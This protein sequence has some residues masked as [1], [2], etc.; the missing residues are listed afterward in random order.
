MQVAREPQPFLRD[1]QLP[2]FF[3][4]GAGLAIRQFQHR[5]FII[6]TLISTRK[7]KKS[8]VSR[9]PNENA[10]ALPRKVANIRVIARTASRAGNDQAVMA[11]MTKNI[12]TQRNGSGSLAITPTVMTSKAAS[13]TSRRRGA[14]ATSQRSQITNQS[15]S[16]PK[17]TSPTT[18][19]ATWAGD[20]AMCSVPISGSAITSARIQTRLISMPKRREP[21]SAT[22]ANLAWASPVE[23]DCRHGKPPVDPGRGTVGLSIYLSLSPGNPLL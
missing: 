13:P 9:N 3:T 20:T 1:R 5:R 11:A 17:T 7:R 22:S 14:G 18:A 16:P 12:P 21:Q 6:L 15:A 23:I 4:R 19:T 8:A 10:T 2:Q